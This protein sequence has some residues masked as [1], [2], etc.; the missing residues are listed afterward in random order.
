MRKKLTNRRIK[1]LI[2][3]V[4]RLRLSTT[5]LGQYVIKNNTRLLLMYKKDLPRAF[6]L[7][8]HFVAYGVANIERYLLKELAELE[9]K[10]ETSTQLNEMWADFIL[11]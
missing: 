11:E 7:Q 4:N 10:K 9:Q 6:E 1:Q 2:T 8:D 5:N 3:H